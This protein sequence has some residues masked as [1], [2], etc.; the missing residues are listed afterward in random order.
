MVRKGTVDLPPD[1]PGEFLDR[2]GIPPQMLK[3]SFLTPRSIIGATA[4]EISL[5]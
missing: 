3:F 1:L 2:E 4:P 5:A